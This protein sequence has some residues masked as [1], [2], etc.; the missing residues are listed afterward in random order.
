MSANLNDRPSNLAA[1]PEPSGRVPV[2][3]ALESRSAHQ[4]DGGGLSTV[5][6]GTRTVPAAGPCDG[7]VPPRPGYRTRRCEA[8]GAGRLSRHEP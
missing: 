7:Q 2:D 4:G 6:A 8:R 1:R 5:T 3:W